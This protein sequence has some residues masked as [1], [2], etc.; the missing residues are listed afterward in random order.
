MKTT[1]TPRLIAA[2]MSAIVT[3]VL[4]NA[5]ALYGHPRAGASDLLMAG[6]PTTV[7]ASASN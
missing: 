3:M 6:R 4:L 7:L 5:V 1:N 2:A